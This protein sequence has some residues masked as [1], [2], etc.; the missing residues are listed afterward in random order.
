[1]NIVSGRGIFL[2]SSFLITVGAGFAIGS[3][4]IQN[5]QEAMEQVASAATMDEEQVATAPAMDADDAGLE[6]LPSTPT[7][8]T[9]VVPTPVSGSGTYMKFSARQGG[10]YVVTAPALPGGQIRVNGDVVVDGSSLTQAQADPNAP[11]KAFVALGVG[12][13]IIE[14]SGA[15]SNGTSIGRISIGLLGMQSTSLA[16]SAVQVPSQEAQQLVASLNGQLLTGNQPGGQGNFALGGGRTPFMIGGSSSS[17]PNYGSAGGQGAGGNGPSMNGGGAQVAAMSP[18]MGGGSISGGGSIASGATSS[19]GTT[20]TTGTSGGT[21]GTT[22]GGGTVSNPITVASP[23][24]T[25]PTPVTPTPVAPTPGAPAP[26][27]VTPITPD[28]MMA[29][30]SPLTPPTNVVLTEA[31]QLTAAGSEMGIVSN[32]GTTMFGQVQD[33]QAFDIVTVSVAPTGRTSTV[34]VGATN[35]QFAVRVFPEDFSMGSDISV[36]LQPGNSANSEVQANP[37]TYAFSGQQPADGLAQALGRVTFGA[38]PELY[39]RVQAI[40]YDAFIEEQLSPETID[41]RAFDQMNPQQLYYDNDNNR[42]NIYRSLNELQIGYAAFTEKQLQE[43]MANFW[44]NHFHASVKGNTDRMYGQLNEVRM[45]YRDLAM[46]NFND[47]LHY[48]SK[49]PLMMHFLDNEDSRAGR[50]NENYAREIM[51][52]H[53]VGVDAGYTDEDIIEVARILTGWRYESSRGS[54]DEQYVSTFVF[55]EGRHDDG[56]KFVS[57]INETFG[58]GLEEGERF[59]STLA[60]LPQTQNYIC[61]KLVQ[62]LVSDEIIPSMQ[63]NCVSAWAATG[64]DVRSLLRA[65]LLDPDYIQN[66]DLKRNKVKTPFE[67]AVST[68]RTLGVTPDFSDDNLLNAFRESMEDG[69][70]NPMFF[71]LP[72]GLAE[73]AEAWLGSAS[74]QAMFDRMTNVMRNADDYGIDTLGEVRAAGLETAEE[75]AAYLLA[76]A[77]ADHY[78]LAEFEALVDVLKGEDGIFEPLVADESDALAQA[79]ALLVV[80]PNFQ[81]Q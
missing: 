56:T 29:T 30:S 1:M 57:F 22:G 4:R 69:G 24:P 9:A 5:A 55:D 71:S 26:A 3:E 15:Y 8:N 25:T 76:L 38:T 43:V 49:S 74:M 33:P 40:G 36:T 81:V 37:V 2:V 17:Q 44:Y 35:G 80:M 50:I 11:F 78:S 14:L 52:L 12:D 62:L 68:V 67:Y 64:G 75:V 66:V 59:V 65:I 47:L 6:I 46:T 13:H 23:S 70:Y 73:N 72:T 27:P 41:D 31:V 28:P 39:A 48:S 10:T 21:T 34:D 20:S 53:T 16:S 58:P 51:E 61:G 42:N 54:D 7:A 45:A 19:T 63:A 60:Q 77:T 32:T 18:N 79:K